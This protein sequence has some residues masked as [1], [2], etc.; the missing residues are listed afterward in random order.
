MPLLL[1]AS[2][3]LDLA[4]S[5][6]PRLS[7]EHSRLAWFDAGAVADLPMP[8]GYKRSIEAALRGGPE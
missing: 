2:G 1:T 5:R 7:H 3:R 4:P 8:E 6:V